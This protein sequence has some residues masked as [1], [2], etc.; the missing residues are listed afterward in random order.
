[1]MLLNSRQKKAG[2]SNNSWKIFHMWNVWNC[3]YFIPTL[4]LAAQPITIQSGSQLLKKHC[5]VIGYPAWCRPNYVVKTYSMQ[6]SFV[7]L[8][9]RQMPA[10]QKVFIGVRGLPDLPILTSLIKDF[11][12][13]EGLALFLYSILEIKPCGLV[14][15]TRDVCS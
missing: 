9:G 7:T 8:V 11:F 12:E 1:M 4:A 15:R 6:I 2:T 5:I 14:S 3:D 10:A 13:R